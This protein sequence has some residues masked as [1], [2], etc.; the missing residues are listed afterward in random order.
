MRG[1]LVTDRIAAAGSG[2]SKENIVDVT[3]EYCAL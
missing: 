2:T 1:Q 3:L